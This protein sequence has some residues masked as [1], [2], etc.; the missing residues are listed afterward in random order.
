MP[1]IDLSHYPADLTDVQRERLAKDL[2]AVVVE[3]F[4][5]YEGAVSIALHPIPA[6]DWA[7]QIVATRITGQE[8]HLLKP[9]TYRTD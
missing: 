1:H 6:E 8:S 7:T 4:G 9:P 3:H 5:T 2:T